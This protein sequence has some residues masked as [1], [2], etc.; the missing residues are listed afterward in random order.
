[1]TWDGSG[2][3]YYHGMGLVYNVEVTVS[4]WGLLCIRNSQIIPGPGN[5]P[6]DSYLLIPGI[7]KGQHQNL[8]EAYPM[9]RFSISSRGLSVL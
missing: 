1:M 4:P 2:I 5:S 3:L 7:W 9:Y 8:A 6:G